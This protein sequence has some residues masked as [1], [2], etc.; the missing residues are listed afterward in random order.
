[1]TRY[2]KNVLGRWLPL[3]TPV[4]QARVNVE[5]IKLNIFPVFIFW[6]KVA[7]SVVSAFCYQYTYK[8]LVRTV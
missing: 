4:L 5:S 6:Y 7:P 3:A 8:D 2:P 1:M